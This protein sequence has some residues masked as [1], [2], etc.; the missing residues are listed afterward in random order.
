MRLPSTLSLRR[1]RALNSR[2]HSEHKSANRRR[3]R[4]LLVESLEDRRLL[5]TAND[6]FYTIHP[7]DTLE[8]EDDGVWSNDEYDITW[9]EDFC[10]EGEW[11]EGNE[12]EEGHYE[13]TG[14][15]VTETVYVDGG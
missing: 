5:A 1:F 14:D 2:I 12:E 13:C 9:T 11:V 3:F 4:K 7:G 10:T 6:D 8:V 15:W